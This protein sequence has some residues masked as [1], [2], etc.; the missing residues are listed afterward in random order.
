MGRQGNQSKSE[1]LPKS[2]IFHS[3]RGLKLGVGLLL[4]LISILI[5]LLC[6]KNSQQMNKKT[7]LIVAGL[8]LVQFALLGKSA[9]AQDA[10]TLNEVVIS[11]TKNDQK[12][13][14]TGKVVTIIGS[15]ELA[16]SS[17]RNLAELLNEQAGITVVGAGSNASKE[18]SLFFRGAA[19][20]YAVILIDGVLITDPSG[21][22]G[23]FDLRLLAIDQ[24][25]KIEILRGGQSTIY[26][27]DAVAGVVNIITKKNGV[28][29]NNVYGVASVGSYGSYKGTIGLSS[30]IDAFTYNLSYSHFKTGGISEA[31]NPVGNT[32]IFDKDGVNQDALNANF[33]VQLNKRIAI[34]PFL[35]YF[36]GKFD[37]DD[38][39]FSDAKNVSTAKHFNGGLNAVYQLDKGKITFNYSH[40]NT[41]RVYE[42]MYGGRYQGKMDLLDA[43]YNQNIGEKLSFLVGLDNRATAVTYYTNTATKEPS[44]NLFSTYASI[45][46]HDL[47][48][49]N[50]EVGGRYNKHNKYGENYTY[51]VTPS[52]NVI[53]E[54]KVFGTVSS[55]FRAPTL[56]ML[57]GQYGANLNLKPEKATTYEAGASFNFLDEKINLRAVAFKRDMKDAIIY[58]A[59]GY[60]NQD[61]QNDKGFEIEPGVKFGKFSINGYYAYV[62]GKQIT[63]TKISDVLLRRPKN[64]YGLN[65][66]IQATE[67]IYLS[68][69]YKFTGERTDSDFSTY[70]SVNKVLD[71]YQL[72]NFYAEYA[73]DKKRVKIFAD[74]KNIT[75]EK[76]TEII[77]YRTMGFNMNAGVSF[78]FK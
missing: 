53:K 51:A 61:Q 17:G 27:A 40:E 58:G 6:V 2:L 39:A 38:D 43:F 46:M 44:A 47:S 25:E 68:A 4:Y 64:T 26:G 23:A 5:L 19:S 8:G 1:D 54:I 9:V 56:D 18:K 57:F 36:E 34:N 45:F 76:Y 33:S 35:R 71:S 3:F 69:N 20:S 78:N 32:K 41:N 28:K 37:Y 60:I 14:Q 11:T 59:S 49:F 65:A 48:I 67:N 70:P 12:Q 15:E 22:G 55:A 16:R 10:K 77:G 75:D 30:K 62:E 66:G 13:S 24:I 31:E 72:F 52:I 42:S 50:L 29:G 63:A 7:K 73:L 74:L 21:T